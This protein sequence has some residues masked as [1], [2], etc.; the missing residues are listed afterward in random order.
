MLGKVKWSLLTYKY[1]CNK[2]HTLYIPKTIK[3]LTIVCRTITVGIPSAA[4]SHSVII[5]THN[6]HYDLII[7]YAVLS[8]K[9]LSFLDVCDTRKSILL[10]LVF[11]S[12]HMKQLTTSLKAHKNSMNTL[13]FNPDGDVLIS[14]GQWEVYHFIT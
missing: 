8:F 2:G 11:V 3:L 9:R 13:V 7:I 6:K 12:D 1:Q 14:G 5:M 10:V 4:H